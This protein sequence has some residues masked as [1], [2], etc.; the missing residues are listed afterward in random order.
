M[1][2][3]YNQC[4]DSLELLVCSSAASVTLDVSVKTVQAKPTSTSTPMPP[5]NTQPVTQKT[6][7][8]V[9]TTVSSSSYCQIIRKIY[10][11][12]AEIFRQ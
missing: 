11:K 2:S 10:K 3:A 6:A 5:V 12:I 4:L 9:F 7:S 8:T 1:L